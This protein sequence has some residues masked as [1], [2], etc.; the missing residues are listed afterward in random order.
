M[1]RD[2]QPE[3]QRIIIE[4]CRWCTPE[5]KDRNFRVPPRRPGCEVCQGTGLI[6][7]ATPEQQLLFSFRRITGAI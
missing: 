3:H 6:R 1:R 5:A 2:R 4:E 7:L